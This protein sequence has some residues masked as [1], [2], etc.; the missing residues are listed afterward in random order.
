MMMSRRADL[1]VVARA[2]VV[3]NGAE[4]AST[5]ASGSCVEELIISCY[6]VDI[7][8]VLALG[9]LLSLLLLLLLIGG[10]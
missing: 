5:P 8:F 4:A 9:K 3:A 10:N 7:F 6:F 1:L 2:A